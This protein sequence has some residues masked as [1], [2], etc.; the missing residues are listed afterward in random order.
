MTLQ[1]VPNSL[2]AD[3]LRKAVNW[4]AALPD[5]VFS[6]KGIRGFF[7]VGSGVF[8]TRGFLDFMLDESLKISA[9]PIS[10]LIRL[11]EKPARDLFFSASTI[12][13]LEELQLHFMH[14]DVDFFSSIVVVSGAPS[15][16]MAY[17][18]V[19]EGFAVLAVFDDRI[20]ER[21]SARESAIWDCVLSE[22]QVVEKLRTDEWVGLAP[23]FLSGILKSYG[24]K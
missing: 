16:W 23:E 5:Y 18:E 19:N 4:Q 20:F 11:Y 24:R 1:S 2:A 13:E 3:Q 8:G 17:E 9:T 22:E 10:V 7:I 6:D 14:G 12:D 15:E 21:W